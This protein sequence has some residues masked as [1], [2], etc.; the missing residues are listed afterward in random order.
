MLE[1]MDNGKTF[2]ETRDCDIPIMTKHFYH[3]AGWAQ[4]ADTEMQNWTSIG[5]TRAL[6]HYPNWRLSASA[7]QPTLHSWC[8]Y[9]SRLLPTSKLVDFVISIAQG[10]VFVVCRLV[11]VGINRFNH[12]T[13]L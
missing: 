9:H 3:Y 6:S 10:T 11:P 4:L 8:S 5:K 7:C 1:S 2:R 13:V 12:S